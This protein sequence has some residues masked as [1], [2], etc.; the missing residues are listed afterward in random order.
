MLLATMTL[1]MAS[2]NDESPVL[3]QK[4]WDGTTNYF[5]P[6][7]EKTFGTFYQPYVG[8]VGDPMPFYDPVAEDFKILYLRD[9][10]PN[11]DMTYHLYG[12]YLLRILHL[13]L[14]WTNWFHVGLSL[15]LMLL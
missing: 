9:L 10:R 8:F 14:H 4:D 1:P 5:S 11:P 6:T 7:E 2:C 12:V 3:T 13:I 15:R